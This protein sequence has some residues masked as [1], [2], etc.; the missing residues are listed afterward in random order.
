MPPQEGGELAIIADFADQ[1]WQGIVNTRHANDKA[2]YQTA[3]SL[4]IEK[5]ETEIAE[6]PGMSIEDMKKVQDNIFTQIDTVGNS[7][8][9][10]QSKRYAQ[11]F[12]DNNEQI[13]KQKF[14]TST[15]EIATQRSLVDVKANHEAFVASGNLDGMEQMYNDLAGNL[16]SQ[17]AADAAL[18]R[19]FDQIVAL[20]EKQ[21]AA[22]IKAQ[23][24]VIV[25]AAIGSAVQTWEATITE[26]N[27]GG[28]LNAA[29]QAIEEDDTIPQGDKQ[30]VGT[31]VKTRITNLQAASTQALEAKQEEDLGKI[32]ELLYFNKDYGA[33]DLA[34][35]ESSLSES[36][37]GKLFSDSQRRATAAAKQKPLSND[38]VEEARLY[39]ESLDIWRGTTSKQ[40]FDKD[41]LNNSKKLDDDA[42]K[43][44]SQS[45][46][47]TLKS[48]QAESLSRANTE[49]TRQLVDFSDEDAFA[50]FISE[51][52]KGLSPDAAKLFEDTANEDRQLQYWSLS[53]YNAEMRQWIEDNP[54]K[55]GKDF[56]QQSEALLHDY[57]NQS[58]D[59]LKIL[60]AERVKKVADE[61]NAPTETPRPTTQAEFDKI[62]KGTEFIDD[63]GVRKV[64]L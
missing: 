25:G 33:A 59:E 19:G 41:L 6:N 53:R 21:I 10:P 36:D 44:V 29:L 12:K 61:S 4:A 20:Q 16:L 54:D 40:E 5:A 52:I 51:S 34:I 23:E 18:D 45:A 26:D 55:T 3:V 50:T 38:R 27:P 35:R 17:E 9:L 24:E 64:K 39:E 14:Q 46:A 11:Q 7:F 60:R 63:D 15:A 1:T 57:W 49:A 43:R 56:F 58:I 47:N 42:Y 62:P 32:N 31:E 2:S 30:E 13:I 48:S 28:D 22:N 37:K 8:D